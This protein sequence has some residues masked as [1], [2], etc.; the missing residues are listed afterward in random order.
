MSKMEVPRP[1]FSDPP[2]VEVALSVQFDSLNKLRVPQLGLLW[3]EFRD[4]FPVTEEHTPL[5]AVVERFG[6]PRV[7][8]G[9]V[10]IEMPESPPTPRCWF[11]NEAGTELIQVQHDRFVH[12]WRK[13]GTDAEYPRYERI[14]RTFEE[15]LRRFDEFIACEQIGEFT[16]NQ[17]EVTYVNHIVGGKGWQDHGDLGN[18]IT[19][20]QRSFSDEFLEVPEDT[21]L[22]LRFLIPDE[23]GRPIGR[24]H[25]VLN[26]GYGSSDDQTLFVL[27]LTAR[28]APLGDGVDGVLRF[29]DL[30]R[31][32]V[33]RGFASLTTAAM[34][35]EWGRRN[36]T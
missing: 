9:G 13:A 29:L 15:E 24:L 28:G 16:P 20:F 27:N 30:G 22:R 8:K 36:G 33:V 35:N 32:W 14:R 26:P 23:E 19:V 17:C 1:D 4:R 2:V 12:N 25:A 5:D 31:E 21:V 18:V 10:K 11:L 7:R 6:A 3:R 34:H